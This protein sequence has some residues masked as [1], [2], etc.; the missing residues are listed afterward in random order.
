MLALCL[1]L[2]EN[3][4]LCAVTN[5]IF[6]REDGMQAVHYCNIDMEIYIA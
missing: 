2:R 1:K 5:D 3:L 4:N 6:T